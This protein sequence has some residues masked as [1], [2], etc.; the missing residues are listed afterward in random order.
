MH[1]KTSYQEARRSRSGEFITVLKLP[2]FH[3]DEMTRCAL[4]ASLNKKHSLSLPSIR[5]H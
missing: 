3:K 2:T 5:Y 1:L 4:R